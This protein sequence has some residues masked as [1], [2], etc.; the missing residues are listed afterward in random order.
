MIRFLHSIFSNIFYGII[1]YFS[2]T[3]IFPFYNFIKDYFVDGTFMG[4]IAFF[5]IIGL[6]FYI[7]ISI[8]YKIVLIVES[9]YHIFQ[10]PESTS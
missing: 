7:Y 4:N 2:V 6:F 3:Y 1:L 8:S 10:K 9:L 5:S